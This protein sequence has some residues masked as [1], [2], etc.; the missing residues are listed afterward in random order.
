MKFA[1]RSF[2]FSVR[3]VEASAAHSEHVA[4]VLIPLDKGPWRE[5]TV[6]D[7]RDGQ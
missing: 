7:D 4:P 2:K 6:R 3:A 5:V 1:N